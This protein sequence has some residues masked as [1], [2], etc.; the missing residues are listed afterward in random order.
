LPTSSVAE[1]TGILNKKPD[2]P[3]QAVLM[4]PRIIHI[5]RRRAAGV[6]ACAFYRHMQG[7]NKL[8]SAALTTTATAYGGSPAGCAR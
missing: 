1:Q 6:D 4:S 8:R 3:P 7:M 5:P 2:H